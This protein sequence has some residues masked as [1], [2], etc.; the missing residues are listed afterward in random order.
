MENT[1][2]YAPAQLIDDSFATYDVIATGDINASWHVGLALTY[3]RIS[4]ITI[5]NRPNH[6]SRTKYAMFGKYV[7]S[8]P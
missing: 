5:W 4:D 1:F 3:Y 7:G 6:E 2:G 8:N